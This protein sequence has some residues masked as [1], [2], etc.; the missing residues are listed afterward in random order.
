MVKSFLLVVTQNQ[1][2]Y[3]IKPGFSS[4][5]PGSSKSDGSSISQI[6]FRITVEGNHH[7]VSGRRLP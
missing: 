2:S 4:E 6:Q 3:N 1:I 5:K 7:M